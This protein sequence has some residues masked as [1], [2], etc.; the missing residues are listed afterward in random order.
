[1]GSFSNYLELEL[2]DHVFGCGN[3]SYTPPTNI[4]VALSTADPGEDGSG[5]AEPTGNNYARKSTAYTDWTVAASGALENANAVTFNEA[6]GSWGTIAHFA[7]FDALTGGNMLGYG[8]L[9]VAKLVGA[10]DTIQ[11]AAGDIDV[12]LT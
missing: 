1:M 7:L 10:G 11:F 4:F 3:R 8:E 2:L 6:S 12:T 9:A 5:M